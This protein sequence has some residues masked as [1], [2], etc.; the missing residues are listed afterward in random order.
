MP[1]SP[2]APP[3]SATP[4]FRLR[5][6]RLSL[7]KALVGVAVTALVVGAVFSSAA[8]LNGALASM[9]DTSPRWLPLLVVAE[10]LCYLGLA[11]Q[12]Q[13]LTGPASQISLWL[14]ARVVV[15]TSGLGSLLPGTPAPGIALGTRELNHRGLS[16]RQAGLSLVW[17]NWFS[18]RAFLVTAVLAAVLAL[19]RGN[20]P[21]G[22]T[23][24]V[25]G[26]GL[27]VLAGLSVTNILLTRQSLVEWAAVL[28]ARA[29]FWAPR[30]GDEA[31]RAR[32][33]EW[34]HDAIDALGTPRNRVIVGVV[35]VGSWLADAWCLRLA[36]VAV[37]ANVNFNAVLLAYTGATL[38]SSIKLIPGG[39][40]IV[41]A[42]Q[43]LILHHFH[44]PLDLALAGTLVWRGFSLLLPALAGLLALVSLRLERRR[45]EAERT[46]ATL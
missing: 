17:L 32:G 16:T 23:W 8:D 24:L 33:R 9:G 4:L 11:V 21:L 14:A 44:V 25:A 1:E 39:I 15:I 6:T 18:L 36:L 28:A 34:F 20:I 12:L 35:S 42:T 45:R 30:I 29:Q 26:A 13:R 31:A 40:G 5:V 22:N 43:P 10:A 7:L 38:A 27:V 37:G 2:V 19:P 3:S 41:E 46:L